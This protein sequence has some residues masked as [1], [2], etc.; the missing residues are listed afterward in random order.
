MPELQDDRED[1]SSL[2]CDGVPA[3]EEEMLL[4]DLGRQ[5][6][7]DSIGVVRESLRHTITLSVFLA[8]GSAVFLQPDV[9]TPAAR[10]L[11]TT[12]FSLALL[13]A[14]VAVLPME[15]V[16]FNPGA[17]GEVRTVYAEWMRRKTTMLKAAWLLLG[18]G[19]VIGFVGLLCK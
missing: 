2:S 17:I 10:W 7:K 18:S 14:Y 4:Y 11:A 5:M 16:Q 3:S 15:R 1:N 9:A 13:V 12:L 8:G 6:F 19:L